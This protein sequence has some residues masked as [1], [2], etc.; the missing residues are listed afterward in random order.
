MFVKEL[1]LFNQSFLILAVNERACYYSYKL[2]L[3]RFLLL[4]VILL[5]LHF[6]YYHIKLFFWPWS[7]L[8]NG[9]KVSSTRKINNCVLSRCAC[10]NLKIFLSAAKFLMWTPALKD[11]CK[12]SQCN[13]YRK[14]WTMDC[15]KF[16][17]GWEVVLLIDPNGIHKNI[18]VEITSY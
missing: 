5:F 18:M 12:T 16:A 13:K 3:A 1:K 10:A 11:T 15:I 6:C 8:Q 7:S 17:Q 4:Y 14:L 2:H 9:Q